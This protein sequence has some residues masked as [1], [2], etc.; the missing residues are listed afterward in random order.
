MPL[1]KETRYEFSPEEITL[2]IAENL[3]VSPEQINVHFS[4]RESVSLSGIEHYECNKIEVTVN[5]LSV[6]MKKG[7]AVDINSEQ[8]TQFSAPVDDFDFGL[9]LS[10]SAPI[11]QNPPEELDE[12]PLAVAQENLQL[13]PNDY[14]PDYHYLDDDSNTDFEEHPDN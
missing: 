7:I 2:F 6:A 11:P 13:N 5:H 1:V 8:T 14:N 4:C 9:G 10:N 12:D 3:G